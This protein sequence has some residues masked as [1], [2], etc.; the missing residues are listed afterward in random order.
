VGK[1]GTITVQ[2]GKTL[3]HEIEVVEGMKFD[4]GYISPYFVTDTKNQKVLFENCLVLLVEKKVSTLHQILPYLEHSNTSKRPL[5]IIAEDVESEAL[6]TLVLNK[7]RGTLNVCAVKAPAFGDNR[8]NLMQDIAIMTGATLI[9]DDIGQTLENSD[10]SV[11]GQAKKIEITKDDTLV[12]EGNGNRAD[13]A[14]RVEQ[15]KDAIEITTSDYD[16]EKLQERLAKL[17]GGVGVI[18]VGGSS[19]VE[20]NEIKD[21]VNDALNATH[22]ALSEGVIVVGGYALL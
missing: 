7:L 6:T 14:A 10:V 5:L 18:K 2:D 21:R 20:V 12:T 15:I 19:E 22:A 11:L 13:L 8:K 9:S 3:T 1:D 16:K 4:R 17:Q